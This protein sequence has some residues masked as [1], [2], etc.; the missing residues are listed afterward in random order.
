[1]KKLTQLLLALMLSTAVAYAA[2]NVKV[3]ALEEFNTTSPAQT[4]DV[5]VVSGAELGGLMLNEGDVI[6]C[7]VLSV[8]PPAVGKRDASFA[9]KPISVNSG[10]PIEGNWVGNYSK[11]VLSKDELKNIDAGKVAV[12]ATKK[13]G[14]L[15]VKGF[16]QGVSF[17][18]GVVEN[19]G[20]KPIRSGIK[21]VYKDSP[22]SYVE[23]GDELTI[24]PEDTFY[25]VFKSAD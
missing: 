3:S 17:A 10:T 9:V 19:K 1:M 12:S 15:F 18:E 20:K 6:H 25:F 2:E 23:K 13:V 8:T 4:I 16:G 21:K 22:L 5:K 7:E 11:R 24:S 14:G